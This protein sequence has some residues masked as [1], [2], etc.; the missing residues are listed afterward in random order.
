MFITDVYAREILDSRGNP[1]VEVEVTLDSGVVGRAAVPSG[2]STGEYEAVELRDKDKSRYLGKGVLKAV[3]NVNDI[4]APELEDM[5]VF[6]QVGIDQMMIELDGTD[7][8]GNLGANAI[9]GVSMAV[10]KAAAEELGMPLYRYLG[11]VNAKTLPV[12]MMNIINGGQHADNNVDIQEFMVMPVGAGSWK[13]ALR[14]G[15][16]IFH[17]LKAVLSA[18]GLNTAVGDEGGFA[19]NLTSNEEALQVIVEAITKAGYKPGEEVRIAMDAA[20]S[21]FYSKEKAMYVLEGEGKELTSAQMVEF[22]EELC[23]KY[24]IVSIEDGLDE[25]DWDGFKLMTEKLGSKIQIVGDDLFVTNTQKLAQGIEKGIANSILIKLNQIG[26]ITETLDAIEMAKLAGYT[27]IVSHR[28]GE[29]EDTTIADLVVATNAGQI[30]TGAPS[31][32]DRVAKYNQLIRIE[33]D[34]EGISVYKGMDAFYN[35]G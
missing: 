15:A 22:Y 18:K 13:E 33:D 11:G 17:A 30:K 29:T 21:S 6:D 19:P 4:I 25:N 3:S 35:I 20:A 32:T 28:S 10:A 9:L 5:N 7:N 1:T 14:M 34:L 27:A 24:P 31:R 2:A 8:K 26:T 16:E 23:A 12:P